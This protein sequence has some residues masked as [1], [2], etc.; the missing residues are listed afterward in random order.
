MHNKRGVVGCR[1]P[2]VSSLA[3]FVFMLGVFC[4]VC[5]AGPLIDRSEREPG[6]RDVGDGFVDSRR[7]S[8]KEKEL[9]P[10]DAVSHG[11]FTHTG[12][13]PEVE[14]NDGGGEH[15]RVLDRRGQGLQNTIQ[16]LSPRPRTP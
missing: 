10:G 4:S 12:R 7:Y 3:V 2:I 15:E 8:A 6:D 13:G 9:E 1:W 5:A 14:P 11:D 16:E